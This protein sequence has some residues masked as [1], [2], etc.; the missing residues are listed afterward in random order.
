MRRLILLV[1]LPGCLWIGSAEHDERKRSIDPEL[2][3]L[4]ITPDSWSACAG[5]PTFTVVGRVAERHGGRTFDTWVEV[6]GVR[7]PAGTT[8][9]AADGG[10]VF[11]VSP[12][13]LAPGCADTC[14]VSFTVGVSHLGFDDQ[15]DVEVA[16]L[17]ESEP[18]VG[19]VAVIGA[20]GNVGDLTVVTPAPNPAGSYDQEQWPALAVGIVDPYLLAPG[21]GLMVQVA[22]CPPGVTPGGAGCVVEDASVAQHAVVG[23]VVYEVPTSAFAQAGCAEGA[24]GQLWDAFVVFQDHPCASTGEISLGEPLRF[25]VP[26]CDVDGFTVAAGDCNDDDP[27]MNPDAEEAW[28]DGVD[29]DCDGTD[30]F[31]RDGDGVLG[32]PK[33]TDCD[34]TDALTYPGAPEICDDS[35]NDCDGQQLQDVVTVDSGG[36]ADQYD[37]LEEALAAARPGDTVRVC[38]GT[39][40]GDFVIDQDITVIGSGP[41]RSI[42]RPSA[43]GQPVIDIVGPL[44][45]RLEGLE[46]TGA[47]NVTG[48][49]RGGGVRAPTVTDLVIVDTHVLA[50]QARDG[51]GLLL[52]GQVTLDQVT[53]SGNDASR[54][55][56]GVFIEREST[57][58]GTDVLVTD[59]L[60]AEG[61]GVAISGF[62]ILDLTSGGSRIEQN[63]ATTGGGGV[64]M[65]DDSELYGGEVRANIA[66]IGG[67]VYAHIEEDSINS[68]PYLEAVRIADHVDPSIER[69][70]AI[71]ATGDVMELYVVDS[72]IEDNAATDEGGAIVVESPVALEFGWAIGYVGTSTVAGNTATRGGAIYGQNA[73]VV[74]IDSDIDDNSAVDGGALYADNHD[75]WLEGRFTGNVAA[76]RGGAYYGSRGLAFG[77]YGG[78]EFDGNSATEGGALYLDDSW[79]VS[80]DVV[81]TGNTATGLG[82]AAYLTSDGHMGIY[83][84]SAVSGNSSQSGATNGAYVTAT[85]DSFVSCPTV[86]WSDSVGCSSDPAA[87]VPSNNCFTLYPSGLDDGQ[88]DICP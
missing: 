45:V 28:Y 37:T 10:V 66:P 55:G 27:L 3:L 58:T 63:T 30:D 80:P 76:S 56:G 82:G 33:G 24:R 62:T 19:Q 5:P 17:G 32:G 21:D 65:L 26:D 87:G 8:T 79:Y 44:T 70:G 54:F 73:Y 25:V 7:S 64:A 69:G 16:I 18:S 53:I 59:N 1:G 51:A 72:T 4:D 22:L 68:V 48:T 20:D 49:L 14:P 57:V 15:V 31:D 39:F 9:A 78:S 50:N 43:G 35:D 41:G 36:A 77:Y 6:D 86:S 34:D 2:E 88:C 74:V 85:G 83:G 84:S 47:T 52:G 46:I 67:G 60:A 42:L 13:D 11:E 12:G 38:P 81:M 29:Q 75:A 23:D 61:G 40:V 71:F